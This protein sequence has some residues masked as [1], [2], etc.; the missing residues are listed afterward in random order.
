MYLVI[1]I[2][3]FMY[4]AQNV[5]LF[6]IPCCQHGWSYHNDYS[7]EHSDWLS[8]PQDYLTSSGVRVVPDKKCGK[9]LAWISLGLRFFLVNS[10]FVTEQ[11]I[12]VFLS[13]DCSE[14]AQINVV[15]KQSVLLNV[16]VSSQELRIHFKE[17]CILQI[18]SVLI[19]SWLTLN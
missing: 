10:V 15:L 5:F 16:V 3:F 11:I 19:E 7:Y 9:S 14:V 1:F 13:F 6:T 18:W 4:H 17:W 8:S 2:V 12:H